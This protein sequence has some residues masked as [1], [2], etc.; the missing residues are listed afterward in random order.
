[1][2]EKNRNTRK[3]K[4]RQQV[5]IDI[6]S[7]EET[8]LESQ[9]LTVF[10]SGDEH[11]LTMHPKIGRPASKLEVFLESVSQEKAHVIIKETWE[12]G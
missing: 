3:I 1:M 8:G 4:L 2:G 7:S 6:L 9:V 12:K 5:S 11:C 10:F